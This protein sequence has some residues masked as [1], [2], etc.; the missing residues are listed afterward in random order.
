MNPTTKLTLCILVRNRRTLFED[1]CNV[2]RLTAP[3]SYGTLAEQPRRLESN[4]IVTDRRVTLTD[5]CMQDFE[6]KGI[7]EHQPDTADM[8]GLCDVP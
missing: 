7:P 5:I 1:T 3:H 2:P 6:G 4:V 8:V